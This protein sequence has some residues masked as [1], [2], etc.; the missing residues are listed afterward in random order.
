MGSS[1]HY[2]LGGN[3]LYFVFLD[4]GAGRGGRQRVAVG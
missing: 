1:I 2:D 3:K 4:P